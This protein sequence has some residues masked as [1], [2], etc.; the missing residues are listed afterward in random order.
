[1]VANESGAEGVNVAILPVA[2]RVTVPGTATT[3]DVVV[4]VKLE[5][6]KVAGF[7]GSLKVA[8][9]NGVVLLTSFAPSVGVKALTNGATRS[10][11]QL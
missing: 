1:M 7:I 6:D 5:V 4:R 9:I 11:Y 3:G 10:M 8:V 2:S